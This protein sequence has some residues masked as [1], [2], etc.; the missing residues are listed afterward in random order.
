MRGYFWALYDRLMHPAFFEHIRYTVSWMLPNQGYTL[1][2]APIL[3]RL[4]K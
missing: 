3:M 4:L 2:D 1:L